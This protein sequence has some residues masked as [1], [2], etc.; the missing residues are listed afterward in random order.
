MR[1]RKRRRIYFVAALLMVAGCAPRDFV[2]G[3]AWKIKRTG[4]SSAA[5]QTV[6][7]HPGLRIDAFALEALRAASRTRDLAQ[8]R[9]ELTTA[10]TQSHE[11][12]QQAVNNEIDRL[13]AS[14]IR[15]LMERY[16]PNDP[17]PNDIR[18]ALRER[19]WMLVDARYVD[20]QEMVATQ[21][22][23]EGVQE[24]A[25]RIRSAVQSSPKDDRGHGFI[26]DLVSSS[27]EED[28]TPLDKG[29]PTIDVYEPDLAAES[30]L[31][32][33]ASLEDRLLVR[34]APIIVQERVPNPSY[35]AKVDLIGTVGSE[36][37]VQRN[38]VV[39]TTSSASLY[40]YA[41]PTLIDGRR[42]TQLT[43]T[44]W[45]PEHPKLK[46]MDAEAG[47]IE[48]ATLRIT[49]DSNGRPS[50]FETVL[51][52]GCYHRCYP[53]ASVEAASCATFASPLLGKKFCVE[54]EVAD[55]IDWV[56]AETVEVADGPNARPIVFSRAGYHG[57]AGV[58]F[59]QGEIRQRTVLQ[60]RPYAFRS[61]MDLERLPVGEGY[62]SMFGPDGL[63]RGARRLEGFL[64]SPTGMLSAGQP[65][66]RG[67]QLLHWDQY[68]FDDPHLLETCLRLPNDF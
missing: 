32:V 55:K 17:E 16:F 20:L 23:V 52:C 38:R 18:Q 30:V 10:L 27:F 5:T 26:L 11:L 41:Q 22:T 66:Q 14:A 25:A 60:H 64:L 35:D 24:I 58:S 21:P 15:S 1:Q 33:D 57:P 53:S 12:A 65:R 48:G 7:G 67:T 50:L 9:L 63:V 44:W 6:K 39:V 47:R 49:L 61:Y 28:R 51:N 45:F 40:G 46:P 54:R 56:V 31:A 19:F 29:G 13:P 62:A 43:Y 68:D 2:D 4:R 34:F 59:D 42:L 3:V 37:T 36:G 8:T